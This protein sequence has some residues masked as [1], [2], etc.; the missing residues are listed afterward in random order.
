MATLERLTSPGFM[1]QMRLTR[2]AHTLAAL[3]TEPVASAFYEFPSQA[4]LSDN[5]KLYSDL[6]LAFTGRATFI[7]VLEDKVRL[8][9]DESRRDQLA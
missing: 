6:P 5:S 9:N 7:Q 2:R 4:I 1:N 8:A 3:A